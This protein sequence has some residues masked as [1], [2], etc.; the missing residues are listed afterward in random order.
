MQNQA[1]NP[2]PEY[3]LRTLKGDDIDYL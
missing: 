1:L 2:D 3:A